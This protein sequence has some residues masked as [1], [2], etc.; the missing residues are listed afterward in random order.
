MTFTKITLS[1]SIL[2]P[3]LAVL[4]SELRRYISIGVSVYAV[5]LLVIVLAQHA[6][7]RPEQAVGLSFWLGV[8]ASFC[9]QKIVTFRDRR[10]HHRV[11]VP[12]IIATGLLLAFNFGFT[13]LVTYL[14]APPLPATIT[15][16]LAL[17]IT[18]LWNF[19]LYKQKIFNN[20]DVGTA[21]I[22]NLSPQGLL[23]FVI[24]YRSRV[25]SQAQVLLAYKLFQRLYLLV[26]L[27]I[28]L[29]T[30]LF[31]SLLGARLQQN[32]A[33][34]LVDPYLI[35]H[36]GFHRALLPATHSFLLKW[37]LFA[38]IKM[39][40]YTATS[41]E[42]FTV[43]CVLATVALLVV[44]LACIERR[45][46]VLGT[47]CLAL[48]SSL[49][50]VPVQPHAGNLLPVN[51]AMIATRNLEYVLFIG[52]LALMSK[53][54]R[55][56]SWQ[57]WLG[58]LGL[59]MLIA[60]DKLFLSLSIG[61]ALLA[62][63][64]YALSEGWN[65]VN[66]S[67]KWLI[68]SVM[69]GAVGVGLLWLVSSRH[70]AHIVSQGQVAPYTTLQNAH[71][72][73]LG[74]LY[75]LM[76]ILTNLGANP[77]FDTTEFRQMPAAALHHLFS[78]SGPAFV[79]NF[80]TLLGGLYAMVWLLRRSFAHNNN[81]RSE[82]FGM[83]QSLSIT[84]IWSA[85]AALIVFVLSKHYYAGDARYLTLWLFAA[86]IALAVFTRQHTWRTERV[87]MVGA[88]L[89]VSNLLAVPVVSQ[90][91][92]SDQAAEAPFISRNTL[93][94]QILAQHP[95]DV[96]AGDYWRVVPVK[97][98]AH[99][100][101]NILPLS[102]CTQPRTTLSS[103]AWQTNLSVHSI[104]YLLNLDGSP[105]DYPH[106]N[107]A[108][109][110]GTYG[111]PNTS[112]VVAGS[113][114][115]PRELL[116]FYDLGAHKSAPVTQQPPTGPA[117]VVPITLDELPYTNCLVPTDMQIVAHQDD[118]LLFMNPDVLHAIQAGHCVRT[119]YVTSGDA[120]QESF[121]WLGREHG[122]EEAYSTMLGTNQLWVERIVQ[123]ANNQYIGVANPQ[124]NSRISLIF[125]HLPDGNIKGQGF[126]RSHFESLTK[127]DTGNIGAIHDVYSGSSYSAV[128]LED[129]LKTLMLVYQPTTIRTQANLLSG[130]YPDHSDHM[131]VGR[132]AQ[133]AYRQYESQQY[134]NKVT[135]PISYYVGYPIHQFAANVSG[136]DLAAKQAAFFAYA[137]FDNGV[138]GSSRTC[139]NNPAY[140]A[141]LR[142]QYQNP[143]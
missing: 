27:A 36:G 19:Y 121:Y 130:Q 85:V 33:D 16:T 21:A 131:A 101:L 102:T 52:S 41:F 133:H 49:L 35:E 87:V 123:V 57:F 111:R 93:V 104:A 12:Q 31:W 84:L 25:T 26:S 139:D 42:V 60:S 99:D 9:L 80:L 6:G 48:A 51:M 132:F 38:L 68:A 58:V 82:Y 5:E 124:G 140:G 138:C 103:L 129:A 134:E 24:L 81:H 1:K 122:S 75:A 47:I 109:I 125:M 63:V 64:A 71:Q 112:L 7:A 34:Q 67:V 110:I 53:H 106:C 45:P 30:T 50:L 91:F 115:H 56:K 54:G 70:I 113:L 61:G 40:G 15:R 126:S 20:E 89:L 100:P 83:A 43:G 117:T 32:N 77:A 13:L 114:Q 18:T 59:G 118:D 29:T 94:A 62:L 108:Q 137:H 72:F 95:V 88:L 2:K 39:L 97:N 98:I 135:I 76:A 22:P 55:L 90:A 120:G 78:L 136:N 44:V 4:S 142:R 86:F 79:V 92:R 8:I 28:L 127:L 14:L 23:K 69:G 116:L 65:L 143:Y 107:L 66:L 119:V 11:L 128:Q 96:L 37:P 141:Y 46:L 17:G 10:L 73:V 105:A 3:S 74:S